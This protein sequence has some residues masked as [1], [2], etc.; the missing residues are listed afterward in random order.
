MSTASRS[1]WA[2]AAVPGDVENGA[3]CAVGQ[4]TTASPA[5]S[6]AKHNGII[7]GRSKPTTASATARA[8]IRT[9][10]MPSTLRK[11]RTRSC[12]R[13]EAE[14]APRTAVT[15]LPRSWSTIL[16]FLARSAPL[17]CL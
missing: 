12:S 16:I 10:V 15:M 11:L 8:A 5:S 14:L 17:V 2:D 9:V 6:G 1:A 13:S 7:V 3:D 4:T